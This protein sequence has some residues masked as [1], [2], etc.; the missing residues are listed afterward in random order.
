MKF[1]RFMTLY[2]L[3]VVFLTGCAVADQFVDLPD[4]QEAGI[5]V[6]AVAL[7]ALAFDYLI[8][9]A[10]WLEFVRQYQ[11]GLAL[12]LSIIAISA[13]ENALPTGSDPIAVPAVGLLIA[14]ALYFFGRSAL[15][16]RGVQGFAK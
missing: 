14:A 16:E 12:S 9:V 4:S 8:G 5:K 15:R 10:P 2:C 7:V 11:E 13:I 3:A 1:I 6:I